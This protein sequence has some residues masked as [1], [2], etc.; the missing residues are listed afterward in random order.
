MEEYH[1]LQIHFFKSNLGIFKTF[2]MDM[3]Y[4]KGHDK[5]SLAAFENN[6]PWN[7]TLFSF[8]PTSTYQGAFLPVGP[9]DRCHHQHHH[10]RHQH[11]RY[12]E[13]TATYHEAFLPVGRLSGSSM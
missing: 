12:I 3:I 1:P 5:T 13:L 9:G 7:S 4:A 10:H 11:H 8:H 2:H 6:P